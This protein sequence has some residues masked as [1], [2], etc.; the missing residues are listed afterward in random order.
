[1]LELLDSL[2][3]TASQ[4]AKNYWV[5][6]MPKL[7]DPDFIEI[8]VSSDEGSESSV[9][10]DSEVVENEEPAIEEENEDG[11]TR[12]K[13]KDTGARFHGLPRQGFLSESS[14]N[15]QGNLVTDTVGAIAI[16]SFGNIAARSSGGAAL[17]QQGRVGPAA[18]R[19]T[20]KSQRSTEGMFFNCGQRNRR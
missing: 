18:R 11:E 7:Q 15:S 8:S 13:K 3:G 14:T 4:S 2:C 5:K 6:M 20:H 9:S 17:K 10:S 19:H 16:D 12:K 1:M